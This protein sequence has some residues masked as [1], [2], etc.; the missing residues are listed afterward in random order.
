MSKLCTASELADAI[1]AHVT[2][3]LV[4]RM[5]APLDLWAESGLSTDGKRF[6]LKEIAILK[7]FC[8]YHVGNAM[9]VLRIYVLTIVIAWDYNMLSRRRS[10]ARN[11]GIGYHLMSTSQHLFFYFFG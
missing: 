8:K 7:W 4:R 2:A 5:P 11:S 1:G 3:R 6:D 10:D 9:Y